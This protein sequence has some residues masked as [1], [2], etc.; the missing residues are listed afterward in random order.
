M[1]EVLLLIYLLSGYRTYQ[2]N[3]IMPHLPLRQDA[4]SRE[5][6]YQKATVISEGSRSLDTA[7]SVAFIIDQLL[8]F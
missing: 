4:I 8:H 6:R 1:W 5:D 7:G 2:G 3:L